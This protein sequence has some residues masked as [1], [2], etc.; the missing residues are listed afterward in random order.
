MNC[1]CETLSEKERVRCFVRFYVE[2][3]EA[4]GKSLHSD[5]QRE[6][7]CVEKIIYLNFDHLQ[8]QDP[9][10]SVAESAIFK[11]NIKEY[12]KRHSKFKQECSEV[13]RLSAKALFLDFI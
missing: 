12:C 5:R 13:R 9:T 1:K 6:L 8:S 10:V 3:Y 4:R 2:L 7:A 11:D